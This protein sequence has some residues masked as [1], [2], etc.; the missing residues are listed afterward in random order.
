VTP[1]LR[2]EHHHH[3]PLVGSNE[4]AGSHGALM[5]SS[6]NGLLRLIAFFKLLKAAALI[7]TGIGALR[8]I[9]ADVGEV[10]EQWV[11][12]LSLD[13]DSRIVNHA[14]ERITNLPPHRF[15]ELGIGSFIYAALFLTEG[16]GLWL[17]KRWAEWFTVIITSSLLPIE[18]YEIFHRP[19]VIKI[20]VLLINVAVVA[21]LIHRI[22]REPRASDRSSRH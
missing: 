20:L 2:K 15:R 5:N 8:L 22:V 21:Y 13:P 9:H 14:I 7:V 17:L 3:S 10:L 19:T 1:M 11:A 12:K 16:I 6:R 18:I 4:F